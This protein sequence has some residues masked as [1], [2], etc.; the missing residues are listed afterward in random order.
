MTDAATSYPP[1]DGSSPGVSL[2]SILCTE[3]LARRPARPPDYEKENRAL[4]TLA[5]ALVHPQSNILQILA[6]T[7]LD[8]TQCDSS[9]LSLLSQDDGGGRFYWPAIAGEWRRHVGG[10]TLRDFG[11]SG[12]VLDQNRA[13]LFQHFERRYPCLAPLTPVAEEC[14]MVPFYVANKAVGTIWAV[15]HSNRRKFDAEDERVMG[16]LGHF[17]SLAYQILDTIEGL[18]SQ[19]AANEE[20]KATLRE[21]SENA[22][23]QGELRTQLI[24][25]TALD[26]VLSMDQQGRITE[27]NAQAEMMFGWRREEALGRAL[28]ET[29]IPERYRAAH[30]KGLHHFLSTGAGPIL[31]RRV[32]ITALSRDGREFPVE[33]SVVPYRLGETWAFS[34]F[35]RDITERNRLYND[36]QEREAKVRRLVDSNLIG[37]FI[38]DFE[39]QII[40]AN[41][42]FLRLVGYGR[43]DLLSR[44]LRWRD[45]TPAEWHAADDERV[46]ELKAC[47]VAQPYEKEY[48]HRSGYR[49]PV[50]V[51]AAV[52]EESG[53]QG[54]AFVVD[55]SDRKSA[56][57]AAS[58]SER[59]Y[60]EVARELAHANRVASMGQ[61]SASIGH[62]VK[63]P[64]AAGVTNALAALRWLSAEPPDLEEVRQALE[65]IVKSG[66]QASDVIGRIHAF[67]KKA[68][69]RSDPLEINEAILEVIALTHGELVKNGISVQ[70]ELAVELPLIQA[71]RVQLQQVILNL[72]INA[73]EAMSGLGEGLREL[74]ISTEKIESDCVV[75]A[76]RDTGPGLPSESL[77]RIFEP[78]FTTKS[79]GLGVGLAICRSIIETHGGRLWATKSAPD[80]ATFVFTLPAH[81]DDATSR[82]SQKQLENRMSALKVRQGSG[83]SVDE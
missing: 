15:M 71:D 23:R 7:I 79:G 20:A 10:G 26:A 61:L 5:S 77:E 47:G 80:G 46:A 36:L 73:I 44:H 43:D 67:I 66:N 50:L 54:V 34:G 82:W 57:A 70:R 1:A 12:D 52:F 53:E 38:W 49:V 51:G 69:P 63:Q 22:I 21:L 3:E 13:L 59:R 81:P 72:T 83:A 45:L 31:N 35:I 25:D 30:E 33:L 8:I 16:T 17:A 48:F 75:V 65:R 56:E 29:I 24:L 39:G 32:E 37:I 4:A 74:F 9:G 58:E 42:A 6:E 19:V 68:P 40:D 41:E 18:K 2:A 78:F 62:E 28:S 27:W 11:P 76:M 55:L 64:I 60:R 14:L